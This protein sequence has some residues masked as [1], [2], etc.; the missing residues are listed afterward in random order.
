M[1]QRTRN[2]MANL[3]AAVCILLIVAFVVQHFTTPPPRP[4]WHKDLAW[5]A[6][7]CATASELARGRSRR[8]A[9]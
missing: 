4:S 7:A 9:I 6:L 3:L 1:T 5:L 8:R 2:I